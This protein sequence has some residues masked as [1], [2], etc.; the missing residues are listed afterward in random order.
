MLKTVIYT[1]GERG[2]AREAVVRVELHRSAGT[3]KRVGFE[4]EFIHPVLE[5]S[6]DQKSSVFD[7]RFSGSPDT[8][9]CFRP[10]L[11]M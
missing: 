5:S 11:D 10:N 2:Q 8:V 6:R 7:M 1:H 4:S 9:T 3:Q